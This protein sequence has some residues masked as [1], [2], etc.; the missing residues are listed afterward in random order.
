MKAKNPAQSLLNLR[1]KLY[2]SKRRIPKHKLP[3]YEVLD[4]KKS[5]F[6]GKNL[7]RIPSHDHDTHKRPRYLEV[8]KFLIALFV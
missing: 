5:H 6:I 3:I 2:V 7:V 1:N 8:V 4:Q